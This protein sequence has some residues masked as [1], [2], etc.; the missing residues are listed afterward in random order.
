MSL[1]KRHF[2][3][4]AERGQAPKSMRAGRPRSGRLNGDRPRNRAPKSQRGQTPKSVGFEHRGSKTRRHGAGEISGPSCL[5][6]KTRWEMGNLAFPAT[7][8][9]NYF[10]T[11]DRQFAS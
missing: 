1:E 6:V 9:L 3:D 2:Q 5:C 11:R 10:P 7:F 8:L 4:G